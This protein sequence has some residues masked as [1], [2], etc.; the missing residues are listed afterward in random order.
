MSTY[1]E[2]DLIVT[3]LFDEHGA[4]VEHDVYES[5]KAGNTA[6]ELEDGDFRGVLITSR[7]IAVVDGDEMNLAIDAKDLL[8]STMKTRIARAVDEWVALHEDE[9]V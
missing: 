5:G 6:F 4:F 7:L 8:S 1:K 2:L 9:W 3:I